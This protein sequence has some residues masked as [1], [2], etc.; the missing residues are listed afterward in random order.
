LFDDRFAGRLSDRVGRHFDTDNNPDSQYQ[1]GAIMR[2]FLLLLSFG[3]VLTVSARAQDTCKVMTIQNPHGADMQIMKLWVVDSANFRV[4]SVTPLPFQLGANESFDVRVCILARDGMSHS[5]QVRYTNTHGTSSFNISMTA[6]SS[7]TVPS[8]GE[9]GL[10]DAW[11]SP[12]PA[13]GAVT[14]ALNRT[15]ARDVEVRLYALD[16]SRV[17]SVSIPEL[18]GASV[19]LDVSALPAGEYLAAIDVRGE[20]AVVR[21]VVVIH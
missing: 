12:N 7:A 17:T 2:H 8:A 18:A 16:G 3:L 4:T 19:P 5:S 13:S 10:V 1:Q 14:I 11:I 20:G 15:G 9:R 21:R 6:P